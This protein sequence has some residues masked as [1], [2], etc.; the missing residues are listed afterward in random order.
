M[1]GKT[2]NTFSHLILPL[3]LGLVVAVIVFA[4]IYE[5]NLPLISTPRA[6]LIALLVV[7]MAMCMGG[8][9]QVGISG[10][11]AS[12]LA[13]V[14]MVLGIILLVIIISGLAGWKLPLIANQI[15]AIKAVG[16]L[17]AVKFVIGT[18]GFFFHW[19]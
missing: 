18:A 3:L 11:W 19:L 2:M 9:G 15:Q 1:K 12:P 7:G 16:I 13:F 5:K 8:I 10:R 6:S 14:G 4:A 17:I